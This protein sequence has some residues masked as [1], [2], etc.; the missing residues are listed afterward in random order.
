MTDEETCALRILTDA[1]K[2]LAEGQRHLLSAERGMFTAIVETR[3]AVVLLA[4]EISK[5]V[6]MLR[7]E[8]AAIN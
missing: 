8:E 1:L 6:V 5:L 7:G 3:Q 4:D 2:Q